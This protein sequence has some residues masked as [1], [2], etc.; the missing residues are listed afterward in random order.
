MTAI[1]STDDIDTCVAFD[2]MGRGRISASDLTGEYKV[3]IYEE[4]PDGTYRLA[5]EDGINGLALTAA[6]PSRNVELYGN[7]KAVKSNAAIGDVTYAN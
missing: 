3:N 2:L 5:T 4:M 1:T 6:Q 7:H